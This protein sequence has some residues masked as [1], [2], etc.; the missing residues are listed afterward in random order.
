MIS[1]NHNSVEFKF[2][3][4]QD[5]F[6]SNKKEDQKIILN[7][8]NCFFREFILDSIFLK[9]LIVF[10]VPMRNF[11]FR[12]FIKSGKNQFVIN[13]EMVQKVVATKVRE[14]EK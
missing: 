14:P 4:K 9:K 13:H 11:R 10:P 1:S 7:F 6:F 5:L 12:T 3:M 8:K 2:S